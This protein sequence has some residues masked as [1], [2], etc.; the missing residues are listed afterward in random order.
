MFSAC[1]VLELEK[2]DNR[3]PGLCL[4][5]VSHKFPLLITPSQPNYTETK[6]NNETIGIVTLYLSKVIL[7]SIYLFLFHGIQDL[8]H[9]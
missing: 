3:Q 2:H 4:R 6:N 9:G 7:S 1:C 8:C 5:K